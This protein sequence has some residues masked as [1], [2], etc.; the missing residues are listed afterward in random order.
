MR[1]VN[2]RAFVLDPVLH[3]VLTRGRGGFQILQ[4]FIEQATAL[5]RVQDFK[6]R[7]RRG[8]VV[9][10]EG[11]E[12]IPTSAHPVLRANAGCGDV[13]D[14]TGAIEL[15]LRYAELGGAAVDL[16]GG[17]GAGGEGF[18]EE[19][20]GVG[21]HVRT[22]SE[23][24]FGGADGEKALVG[25]RLAPGD[26]RGVVEVE[27]YG[28]EGVVHGRA[29]GH[30]EAGAFLTDEGD[31]VDGPGHAEAGLHVPGSG[32]EGVGGVVH[33][34]E[35][36]CAGAGGEGVQHPG[37][38]GDT[39]VVDEGEMLDLVDDEECGAPPGHEVGE[40]VHDDVERGASRR[41]L[42]FGRRW[43]RGVEV[44]HG[45]RLTVAGVLADGFGVVFEAVDVVI[46]RE[47][48]EVDGGEDVGVEDEAEVRTEG[49]EAREE[50]GARVLERGGDDDG[51]TDEGDAGL[52][53]RVS[54]EGD[55]GG[56]VERDGGLAG[57]GMP[58]EEGEFAHGDAVGPEPV[59]GLGD[60]E[61]VGGEPG[62]GGASH[63]AEHDLRRQPAPGK[64]FFD[65]ALG[66]AGGTGEGEHLRIG[67]VVD[68]EGWDIGAG[69]DGTVEA[70]GGDGGAPA[71]RVAA[72]QGAPDGVEVG[73]LLGGERGGCH[74]LRITDDTAATEE[75]GG[76]PQ[77][78]PAAQARRTLPKGE[79]VSLP[80]RER[81]SDRAGESTPIPR[82]S[83]RNPAFFL[84]QALEFQV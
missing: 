64:G 42:R 14:G 8:C 72:A 35:D 63:G 36:G 66:A 83:A 30:E 58:G 20:A 25:N 75:A 32:I 79:V 40:P 9:L 76:T 61:P 46:F 47:I 13:A 15:M 55:T 3:Q 6:I 84:T 21:G 65:R 24:R 19:A 37:D 2:V 4:I 33:E 31:G 78:S 18:G 53:G 26:R 71:V 48:G 16:G 50:G 11:T 82:E 12:P 7:F 28:R 80:S 54:A 62:F 44:E 67:V 29:E 5:F 73:V 70:V 27:G 39:G 69:V 10:R 59:G 68:A 1:G 23:R 81:E 74:S 41:R 51:G 60:E 49:L 77:P 38:A 45:R 34:G 22:P 56:D 57:G 52:V 43:R 17:S